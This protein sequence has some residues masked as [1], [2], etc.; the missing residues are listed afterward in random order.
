VLTLAEKQ[1]RLAIQNM[2]R[3]ISQGLVDLA[4]G[5]KNL[6]RRATGQPLKPR[7][8]WFEVTD[9][10]NSRCVH[11]AIWR[12]EPT[13]DALTPDE[14]GKTFSD[15]LFSDVRCILNAGGE[16]TLR[17]DFNEILLAEHEAL[18][19]AS[20]TLSTNGLLP[21]RAINT[22]EFA[23][24][25]NINLGVGISLDGVGENHDLIRGVKGNFE[26]VDK[27]SHKVIALREKYGKEK[28]SP[29][30]GF[31][32][33]DQTLPFLE[34]V[35]TYAKNL[36]IEL[37]VQWYSQS[38]F[39][40]NI[41]KN[42]TTTDGSMVKTVQSL[43]YPI[44]RELWLKWLAG[45]SI[46]FHCFAMDTFCALHC[47]GDIVPCLSLWDTKAGNVRE[48][49]PTA[50][51]SDSK[52]KSVRETVKSC[53]GCLNAWGSR[54]S[55]ESSFYPYLLFFLRHPRMLAEMVKSDRA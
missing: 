51:W 15:P 54:W 14:I 18:P 1:G 33:S 47:N 8:L 52:A 10:C 29:I 20:L 34:E 19:K 9:R 50:L 40:D 21:E 49:S 25:H 45:K 7:W 46:R 39:Y 4:Y 24:Q 17:Q 23:I 28:I 3:Y 48:S 6:A 55:F 13:K 26:K 43:P 27:L 11:C 31:T 16:P 30:F 5:I 42:L 32:L 36:G 41:G 35:R 53:P 37:L 44:L 22:I 38:P 12:K 2:S